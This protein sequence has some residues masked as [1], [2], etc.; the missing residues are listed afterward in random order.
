MR[1]RHRNRR[2]SDQATLRL[3][4]PS[5]SLRPGR[6]CSHRAS[7]R[8][9]SNRV[10]CKRGIWSACQPFAPPSSR[11]AAGRNLSFA[12]RRTRTSDC[13]RRISA[14]AASISRSEVRY[15]LSMA[16][17]YFVSASAICSSI[18]SPDG[19]CGAVARD[20]PLSFPGS[21]YEVP[22]HIAVVVSNR[23]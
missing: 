3:D 14:I 4:I 16:A 10:H 19:G 7:I 17:R 1:S 12:G 13:R 8:I 21:F 2:S 5:K 6:I 9:G 22:D 23:Q 18:Q 11:R 20:E 15:I